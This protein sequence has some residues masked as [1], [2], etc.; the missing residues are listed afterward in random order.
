[1]YFES[2]CDFCE[3]AKGDQPETEV[4][5]RADE[6]M[7]FFPLDPATPGHTLVI[8]R[9]HVPDLWEV[10]AKLG[11]EL[12]GVAIRMGQAIQAALRPD[13]LN[14]ITSSGRVAEQ[15][16]FHLH[17]HLVPRWRDDGFG[18]IWPMESRYE[19]NDLDVRADRIQDAYKGLAG[20]A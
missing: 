12:M 5:W 4:I 20:P 14:L 7:A 10:D 11:E 16:V 8:P 9:R 17:L 3:I 19:N 2:G 15:S 18:K 6:W 1:M 13:G